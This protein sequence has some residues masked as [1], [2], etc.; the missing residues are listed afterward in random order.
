VAVTRVVPDETPPPP[1]PRRRLPDGFPNP[2]LQPTWSGATRLNL[3]TTPLPSPTPPPLTLHRKRLHHDCCHH[4]HCHCLCHSRTGRPTKNSKSK[5]SVGHRPKTPSAAL[6]LPHSPPKPL[7]PIP[8]IPG[9]GSPSPLSRLRRRQ[10]ERHC[11]RAHPSAH[12][13][14]LT[15]RTDRPLRVAPAR[16]GSPS[17]TAR[18]SPLVTTSPPSTWATAGPPRP[19]FLPQRGLWGTSSGGR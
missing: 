6:W 13:S 1:R 12:R 2:N 19:P 8:R 11:S 16:C 7:R 5:D 14:A 10:S 15:P 18:G 3:Q 17:G 9:H 4:L